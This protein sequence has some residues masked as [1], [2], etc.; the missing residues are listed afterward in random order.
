M[1]FTPSESWKGYRLPGVGAPLVKELKLGI[2]TPE[3]WND[4]TSFAMPLC[5]T[6]PYQPLSC[7]PSL[8]AALIRCTQPV[9]RL[10][11][12]SIPAAVYKCRH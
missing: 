10:S 8:P 11:S 9:P 3:S 7:P 2:S 12:F 6:L 1:K 5:P 4:E